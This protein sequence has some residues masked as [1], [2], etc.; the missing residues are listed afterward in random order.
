[1]KTLIIFLMGWS[2]EKPRGGVNARGIARGTCFKN[3][4][5]LPSYGATKEE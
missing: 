5:S 3:A 1:M 2:F 4:P